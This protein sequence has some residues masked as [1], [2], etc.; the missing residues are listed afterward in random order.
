MSLEEG[1]LLMTIGRTDSLELDFVVDQRDIGR[2]RPGQEVRLR[3]EAL[4]Q[5][6]FIGTVV[7]VAPQGVDSGAASGFPVRATVANSDGVLRP[8]QQAY[9]RVLTDRESAA[10]RLLRG[11]ARWIR[12]QWW[13]LWS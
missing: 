8:S 7:S 4:P 13:R 2:V 5:R 9:V 12:L 10:M 3:T 6:T 11:P 1:D